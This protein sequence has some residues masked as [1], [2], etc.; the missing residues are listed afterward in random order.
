MTWCI[1]FNSFTF[2]ICINFSDFMLQLI[3]MSSIF[4]CTFLLIISSLSVI[5]KT[6]ITFY[7]HLFLRVYFALFARIFWITPRSPVIVVI[8]L[9]YYL[10]VFFTQEFAHGLS[11][12]SEWQQ[13]SSSLQNYESSV[14]WMISAR[15]PVSN[16]YSPLSKHFWDRF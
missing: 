13:V 14:L 15:P 6:Y 7:V 16:A 11:L 1:L 9:L 10:Q 3:C 2:L 4:V 8:S 12:E 5:M